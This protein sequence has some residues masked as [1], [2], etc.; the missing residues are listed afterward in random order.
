[1]ASVTTQNI[2][3]VIFL[4]HSGAGKTTT[5]EHLLAHAKAIPKA[6]SVEQGNTVSDYNKDEIERKTSINS[7]VLHLT[8]GG[9][10][11]N[12]IDTPGYSDF[13]G[14]IISGLSAADGAVVLINAA[15]GIETGTNQ[16]FKLIA[17]QKLPCLIFVNRMD[18]ENAD[19]LKCIEGLRNVFGKKCVV[20]DYPAGKESSFKGIANLIIHEGLDLIEGEEKQKAQHE[21]QILV[22]GVAEADDALLEKY[23]GGGELTQEEIKSVFRKGVLAGNIIPVIAGSAPMDIGIKELL[24]AIVNYLPSPADTKEKT[25]INSADGSPVNV[26]INASGPFRAQVFK[27]ISDTFVGQISVFKIYSGIVNTNAT[28]YNE[29]KRNKEKISQLSVLQGKQLIPVDSLSAGDIGCVTKLKNTE[30]GDSFGDEKEPVLFL[31]LEMPEP[32]ISYSVKPKSRADE[33]KISNAIHRLV[34]EDL[35]FK[36]ERDPQTKE[37]VVSGMGDLHLHIMMNRLQDNFGVHV[38]IGTPKV[39]YRETITSNGDSKY[40]HRKQSG[41]AGQFAEV[42]MRVEPLPRGSGFEFV[43]EV[44][45]GSIPASFLVSCEKGIRNAL[46]TGVIA[47]HP[48]VDVRAVVY[49]GKTHPVDSKDIA[50]Q[51]AAKHGFKE[52]FLQ[53][54]PILLEPIMEAEFIVPDEYTGVVT[55][56]LNSRRGRIV[57]MGVGEGGYSDIKASVPLEEMYKYANE[58]KSITAGRGT[59]T[60]KFAHYEQV[61][62]NVAQNII[63]Q[64]KHAKEEETEE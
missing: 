53:A 61:P 57:E 37:L 11:V 51:I 59:Y 58:L 20:I 43:S 42:W 35:S 26:E 49:D 27:T 17:K 18:K 44:V 8:H 2:R 13:I 52:A 24:N 22:E 30:T 21:M 5:I 4:S 28:L 15:V 39:A 25:G 29:N 62:S 7:A 45:G 12:L 63:A 3:N 60:M 56:S 40:K 55:G 19:F 32:V 38:D 14:E 33:D 41:G 1:M 6:G 46:G 34:M 48:V 10:K 54:K 16:A 23:L 50:F 9:V 64:A 31:A 36:A 47:G